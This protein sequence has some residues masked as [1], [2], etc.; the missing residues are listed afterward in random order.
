[1]SATLP[2]PPNAHEGRYYT[3]LSSLPHL[4]HFRRLERLPIPGHELEVRLGM[5][6]DHDRGTLDGIV[7]MMRWRD[8]PILSDERVVARLEE[9]LRALP[10][11]PLRDLLVER[12]EIRTVLAALRRRQR[13]ESLPESRWGYGRFVH[14]IAKN[15]HL[16]DFGLGRVFPWISSAEHFLRE[17]SALALEEFLYEL[18]WARIGQ[19]IEVTAPFS[20]DHVV[21]YVLRW[22]IAERWLA[23]QGGDA[24][25]V[26]RSWVEGM[27]GEHAIDFPT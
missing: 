26:F 11:G 24:L 2:A 9:Q 6:S 22:D 18:V 12:L 5:L 13:G 8:Q 10:E 7:S 1:M 27:V 14:A 15:W 23:T 17:G 21:A 19:C 3:L 16:P 20:F 25:A 4:P